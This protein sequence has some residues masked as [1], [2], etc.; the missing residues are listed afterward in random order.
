MKMEVNR[1]GVEEADGGSGGVKICSIFHCEG[2]PGWFAEMSWGRVLVGCA[3]GAVEGG[4]GGGRSGGGPAVKEEESGFVPELMV[5]D[6]RGRGVKSV[7]PCSDG[8]V[9]CRACRGEEAVMK[10]W[11][12]V[13]GETVPRCCGC[14][15]RCPS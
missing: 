9:A 4:N 3:A 12:F 14:C 7:A 11:V 10:S 8:S 5:E 15:F 6:F 2:E 1:A 13:E